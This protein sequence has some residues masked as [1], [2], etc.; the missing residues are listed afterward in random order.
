MNHHDVAEIKEPSVERGLLS[1]D[2]DSSS[3]VALLTDQTDQLF[4]QSTS[5][6][7]VREELC[8]VSVMWD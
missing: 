3:E 2:D 5:F 7:G 8:S 4:S 1:C 6:T